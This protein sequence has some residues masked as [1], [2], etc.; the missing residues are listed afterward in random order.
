[1]TS[2]EYKKKMWERVETL[3]AYNEE[4][5]RRKVQVVLQEEAVQKVSN[6]IYYLLQEADKLNKIV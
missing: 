2:E 3:K 1:M 4:L 6:D 5:H